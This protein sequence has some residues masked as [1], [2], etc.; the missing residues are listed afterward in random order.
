MF[1]FNPCLFVVWM[2]MY[3]RC[4]MGT[5]VSSSPQEGVCTV[6]ATTSSSDGSSEVDARL[7]C[8]LS[9]VMV[10]DF[11][12]PH[13]VEQ[14]IEA[15]GTASLLRRSDSRK[16]RS[17]ALP[18]RS[19]KPSGVSFTPLVE[20][21]GGNFHENRLRA[22]L[23]VKGMLQRKEQILSAMARLN[24]QAAKLQHE[25]LKANGLD[26]SQL[27]TTPT[28]FSSAALKDVS[29]ANA[30]VR[31]ALQEQHTWLAQ[32]L[33]TTNEYLKASLLQLNSFTPIPEVRGHHY[34]C[35]SHFHCGSN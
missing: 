3:Q 24:E 33:E 26:K 22:V 17:Q 7:L 9:S 4:L 25:S 16:K 10:L 27:W 1:L 20:R 5:V 15:Q 8:P 11:L 19:S 35:I 18:A 2:E 6:V 30:G 34:L 12:Q 23:A 21:D 29:W 31:K 14:D 13:T 28:R 32:N